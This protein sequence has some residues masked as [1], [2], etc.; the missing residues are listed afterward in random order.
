MNFVKLT[1]SFNTFAVGSAPVRDRYID[2][3]LEERGLAANVL[4]NVF[5]ISLA[6]TVFKRERVWNKHNL[7]YIIFNHLHCISLELNILCYE[8]KCFTNNFFFVYYFRCVFDASILQRFAN[9]LLFCFPFW[10]TLLKSSS[11]ILR[12]LLSYTVENEIRMQ[13]I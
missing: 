4:K 7:D 2:L 5:K 13:E 3:T 11:L 10:Y 9:L 12:K 6:L 1:S 8:K